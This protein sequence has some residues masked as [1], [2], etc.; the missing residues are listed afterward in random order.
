MGCDVLL[1]GRLRPD[2][3]VHGSVEGVPAADVRHP[4]AVQSAVAALGGEGEPVIVVCETRETA[5]VRRQLAWLYAALP[6]TPIVL[7][8]VDGPPLAVSAVATLVNDAPFTGGPGAAL[9]LLD[10][11]RA[12]LW[13]GVWL[14]RVARLERPAPRVTQHLRSWLPGPGF[15]ALTNEAEVLSVR[16]GREI[17][18]PDGVEPGGRLLVAGTGAP[19]WL[20]PAVEQALAVDEHLP[21]STWRDPRDT[22]GVSAAAELV[23]LPHGS[24]DLDEHD[25][26]AMRE[27]EGCGRRNHRPVCAFCRMSSDSSAAPTEQPPVAGGAH[28]RTG[29]NQ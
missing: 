19:D 12:R 20:V 18:P 22:Y 26:A 2:L 4:D 16:P 9:A 29:V 3:G 10:R 6:R 14:P 13:S 11:I 15:L 1:V 21:M 27:C 23:L 25:L 28:A 24:T 8:P 5:A 17:P 7:E